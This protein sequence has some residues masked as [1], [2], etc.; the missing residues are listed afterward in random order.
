MFIDWVKSVLDV[1]LSA[2][3]ANDLEDGSVCLLFGIVRTRFWFG[4]FKR[5]ARFLIFQIHVFERFEGDSV[6][7]KRS[8]EENFK[9][10]DFC[11]FRLGIPSDYRIHQ[12][13]F[14]NRNVI[15]F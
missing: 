6:G 2:D 13:Y 3:L 12:Y 14:T 10:L 15:V 9:I 1:S 4:C 11:F 8:A 5:F 7:Q